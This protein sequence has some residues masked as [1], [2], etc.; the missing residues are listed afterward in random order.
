MTIAQAAAQAD[1][2]TAGPDRLSPP[3]SARRSPALPPTTS[4]LWADTV[5]GTLAADGDRHRR[6]LQRGGVRDDRG[7]HRGGRSSRPGRRRGC[8]RQREPS[9]D[10]RARTT[11]VTYNASST[12]G[13][14]MRSLRQALISPPAIAFLPD[15]GMLVG[16]LGGTIRLLAPPY[17][18][19]QP[20]PFL[21]LSNVG[22]KIAMSRD[23]M[24]L[25]SI[26]ILRTT[27]TFYV[28]YTPWNPES[29]SSV[30]LH[31]E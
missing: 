19:P 3:R 4:A 31:R 6:D 16:E 22:R 8:G 12:S 13:F 15:G 26:P 23:C 17:T 11:T 2:T 25:P 21:Q 5:G 28:Y 1:P 27:V 9:V 7:W 29:G 24:L 14:G 30:A 18:Q 10:R 20:T